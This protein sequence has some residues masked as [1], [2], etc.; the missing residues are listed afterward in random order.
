M[1][2]NA[3]NSRHQ[4]QLRDLRAIEGE[5][6]YKLAAEPTDIFEVPGPLHGRGQQSGGAAFK[7]ISHNHWEIW[8]SNAEVEDW[9]SRCCL[10]D[11]LLC[12]QRM[13]GCGSAIVILRQKPLAEV[14]TREHRR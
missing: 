3:R 9:S 1:E 11:F 7:V 12:V 13:I 2:R 6:D 14:G 4:L 10:V 5:T 8:T